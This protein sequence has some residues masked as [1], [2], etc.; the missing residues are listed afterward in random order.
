MGGREPHHVCARV[1]E[2]HQA[3]D[4]ERPGSVAAGVRE[5]AAGAVEAAT[6]Q[7]AAGPGEPGLREAG[8]AQ[9]LGAGIGS[10]AEAEAFERGDVASRK[11]LAPGHLV[12]VLAPDG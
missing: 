7:V 6:A 12:A 11:L 10:A 8:A 3:A 1:G 2:R 5:V 4:A 9:A